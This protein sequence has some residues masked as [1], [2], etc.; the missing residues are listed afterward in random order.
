M[1]P[2]IDAN[3]VLSGQHVVL[4]P[5]NFKHRESLLHAASDGKLWELEY[6]SVPSANTLDAYIE[7]AIS[8]RNHKRQQPFVVYQRTDNKVVG[9][10][11]FYDINRSHHNLAIGFTWYSASV[12]QTAVNT[13]TKL[14]LLTHAF[15]R[16]GCI[17]VAFHTDNLNKRSQAAI[18]RLGAKHEGILRNHRL[19]PN[20]RIRH[21]WCYSITQE[22][23]PAIRQKL[24]DRLAA[25]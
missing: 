4:R 11:R 25:G 21:T 8:E 20:G 16:L 5:L 22:E 9:C 19:L 12:Q 15:D 2:E 17:A 3:L 6:A 14:L 13:E 1:L 7:E 24:T 18:L 10:T 23:W